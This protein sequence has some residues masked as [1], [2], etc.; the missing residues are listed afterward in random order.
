MNRRDWP[1]FNDLSKGLA[2]FVV[3]FGRFAR[4][5]A[6]DQ[7]LRTIGIETQHPIPDYLKP[8][9]D[10]PT[11]EI[12]TARG[13]EEVN[14]FRRAFRSWTGLTPSAYR[15]ARAANNATLS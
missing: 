1:A 8:E 6:V 3:Q 5:L 11:W 15:K 4:C 14:A 12:A 13:Y 9:T 7:T 10:L 2:P